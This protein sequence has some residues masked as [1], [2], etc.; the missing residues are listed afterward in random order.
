V[1][2]DALW[3]I[4]NYE[5]VAILIFEYIFRLRVSAE[6]EDSKGNIR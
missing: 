5:A 2:G 4:S 1:F 3:E 6:Y